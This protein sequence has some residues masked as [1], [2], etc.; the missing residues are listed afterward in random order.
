M[1][2]ANEQRDNV[3]NENQGITFGKTLQRKALSLMY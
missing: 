1:F 2:F 3:R